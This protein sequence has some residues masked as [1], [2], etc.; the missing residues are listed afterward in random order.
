MV[1]SAAIVTR[2]HT[3][4]RPADRLKV[5]TAGK[6]LGLADMMVKQMTAADDL[7]MMRRRSTA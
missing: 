1:Y 7:Q 2:L 6:G 5:M 4:W 3:A